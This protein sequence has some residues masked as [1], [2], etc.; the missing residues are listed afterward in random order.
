MRSGFVNNY[1]ISLRITPTQLYAIKFCWYSSWVMKPDG[2]LYV[3]GESNSTWLSQ[4]GSNSMNTNYTTFTAHADYPD[5][6]GLETVNDTGYRGVVYLKSGSNVYAVGENE[7]GRLGTNDSSLYNARFALSTMDEIPI[8]SSNNSSYS[9]ND[10]DEIILSGGQVLYSK[11]NMGT[12]NIAYPSYGYNYKIASNLELSDSAG[13]PITDVIAHGVINGAFVSGDIDNFETLVILRSDG[14]WYY[15]ITDGPNSVGTAFETYFVEVPS[16]ASSFSDFDK[17]MTKS[18]FRNASTQKW[19]QI[20][21]KYY[22][23]DILDVGTYTSF[24]A[25]MIHDIRSGYVYA[26]DT[27]D[28][29]WLYFPYSNHDV[30][31][32]GSTVT[33]SGWVNISTYLEKVLSAGIGLVDVANISGTDYY[34]PTIIYQTLDNKLKVYGLNTYGQLGTG[35][36]NNVLTPEEITL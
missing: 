21:F 9:I 18:W 19:A 17:G 14:N 36:T 25:D 24:S 1:N 5:I 6:F 26:I 16:G 31:L 4:F 20:E 35:D 23:E 32:D 12:G 28:N 15:P 30:Y 34:L 2:D 7:F 22:A 33:P 13:D 27:D 10:S 11:A 8:I 3:C 29:L